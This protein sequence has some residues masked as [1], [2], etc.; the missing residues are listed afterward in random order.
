MSQAEAILGPRTSVQAAPVKVTPNEFESQ[1][2]AHNADETN[3]EWVE[4]EE[5][6]LFGD[7][8]NGVSINFKKYGPGKHF[9]N[10]E[11]AKELRRLLRQKTVAEMRVLQPNQDEKMRKIMQ[12]SPLGPTDRS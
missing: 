5:S 7:P 4:V 12:K 6:D 8:S 2:Q 3:W 11:I 10:P 1:R 9:V